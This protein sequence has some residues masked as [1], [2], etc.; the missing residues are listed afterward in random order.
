MIYPIEDIDNVD[1]RPKSVGLRPLKE[2]YSDEEI[3]SIR[4]HL[5][6]EL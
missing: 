2:E 5:T 4:I 1:V 3:N 6:V